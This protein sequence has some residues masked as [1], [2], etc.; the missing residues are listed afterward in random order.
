MGGNSTLLIL[1]TYSS[2]P[3]PTPRPKLG[4]LPDTG[5]IYE[6]NSFCLVAIRVNAFASVKKRKTFVRE[7]QIHMAVIMEVKMAMKLVGSRV[8]LLELGYLQR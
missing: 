4:K 2:T 7:A 6:V 8:S 1:C 5:K 3:T